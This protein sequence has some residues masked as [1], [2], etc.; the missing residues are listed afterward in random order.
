MG[1][2]LKMNKDDID[3]E[4]IIKDLV[5]LG[6]TLNDARVYLSLFFLGPSKPVQISED[7]KVDRSR[8]YDSLRR[9]RKKG[10]ITEEPVKI[11]PMYKT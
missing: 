6:F 4:K 7:C 5:S 3:T 11:S 1:T 8:V 9:L 2:N 10:Y